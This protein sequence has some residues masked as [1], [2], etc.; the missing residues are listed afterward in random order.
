MK[1]KKKGL[2][3]FLLGL[4]VGAGLGMLF[5]PKSGEELRKDLKNK[6]NDFLEEVKNLDIEEIKD[7]FFTKLDEIKLEIEELDK[8]KVLKI[9]KDKAELLKEKTA[10]LIELAKEKGTPVLENA[11][12][13]IRKKAIDV[14]REVLKKSENAK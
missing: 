5:A 6:I 2:G 12:G 14:T 11:A 8:E 7:E 4:G 3:K 10:E 1:N 13:E 9:A